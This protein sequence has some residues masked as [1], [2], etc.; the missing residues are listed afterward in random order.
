MDELQF[1]SSKEDC[2]TLCDQ[3][4]LAFF[5]MFATSLI[6]QVARFGNVPLNANS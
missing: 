5:L 6:P 4:S 1:A 3:V 2:Q